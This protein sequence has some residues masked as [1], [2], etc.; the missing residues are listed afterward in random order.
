MK[1]EIIHY[2]NL[3]V[4]DFHDL[5]ALRISV[6][7]VEQN[8]P[9]QELDGKDKKAWHLLCKHENGA[10]VGTLRILPAGV[11]YSEV[12]IGRVV[13]HPDYRKDKI[14]HFIM[15]QAMKFIHDTLGDPNVRISAQSHLCTFYEKY[16]FV[17]TGKEYLEDDIPHS[18]MLFTAT[19]P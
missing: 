15:A 14:G 6:F 19:K 5:V 17:K 12:S 1:Q 3:S 8:C 16:G 7:V 10:L 11:S 13:S 18:E 4:N 2:S 9:Y